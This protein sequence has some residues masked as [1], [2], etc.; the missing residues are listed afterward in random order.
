MKRLALAVVMLVALTTPMLAQDDVPAFSE[1]LAAYERG[2]YATALRVFKAHAGLGDAD[3][4][5][6]LG[7]M[8]ED[9]EGT[10][11]DHTE[12]V[13]W[14]LLA[15]E[16]GH[17]NAQFNLGL[18]YYYGEDGPQDHAEA[19]KWYRLAAEQGLADAQFN[20]GTMYEYGDGVPQDYAWAHLWYDLAAAQG[21][22]VAR[23]NRDIVAKQMTPA[24]IAEAQKMAREWVEK[25]GE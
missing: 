3:A 17:A 24:Q 9:G 1:G 7:T 19:V 25:H 12:A 5:F 23:E 14:Y 20:L 11:Q 2:D 8:Y 22:E 16:Q 21:L 13:K 18:K 4:Q 6:N 15:A 10:P